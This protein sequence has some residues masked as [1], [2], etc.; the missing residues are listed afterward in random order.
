MHLPQG[1]YFVN[2]DVAPLGVEDAVALARQLPQ[3]I[4]VAAIPVAVFCHP[5]GAARN[6]SLLRF[7]FCKQESVL[8]EAAA[9]LAT[10]G[11]RL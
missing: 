10:L 9:R 1:G 8:R 3:L 6:K 11:E 5:E 4:G 2:A 7:A